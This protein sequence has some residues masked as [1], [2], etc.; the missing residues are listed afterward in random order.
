M[1]EPEDAGIRQKSACF[2]SLGPRAQP[3]GFTVEDIR[4]LQ[5]VFPKATQGMQRRGGTQVFFAML[6]AV[7]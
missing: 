1:S 2:P 6:G 3:F 7:C 5:S 4:S